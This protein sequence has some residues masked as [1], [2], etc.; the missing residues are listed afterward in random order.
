MAVHQYNHHTLENPQRLNTVSEE[1][2]V[3]T[4]QC[5]TFVSSQSKL[6]SRC[7]KAS[8]CQAS[9]DAKEADLLRKEFGHRDCSS[10]CQQYQI[11]VIDL[12]LLVLNQANICQIISILLLSD[13]SSV[14]P[15]SRKIS[16]SKEKTTSQSETH[17]AEYKSNGTPKDLSAN[18]L[19]IAHQAQNNPLIKQESNQLHIVSASMRIA[20]PKRKPISKPNLTDA[21]ACAVEAVPAAE[22]ISQLILRSSSNA[23]SGNSISRTWNKAS[24]WNID[25]HV[26]FLESTT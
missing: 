18:Y 6:F 10:N 12:F 3:A 16:I 19:F 15:V 13:Q 4:P 23:L 1:P 5:S 21:C 11:P 26:H 8:T 24:L 22:S 2:K 25:K 9:K 20:S 7:S 14:F 17:M